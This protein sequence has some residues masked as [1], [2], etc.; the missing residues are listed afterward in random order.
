MFYRT[1]NVVMIT[2]YR[3]SLSMKASL[4]RFD[5]IQTFFEC[6]CEKEK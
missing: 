1:K 6:L 3:L 5:H 4:P 2:R